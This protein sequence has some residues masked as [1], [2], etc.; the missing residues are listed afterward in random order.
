M[1][2]GK[3]KERTSRY[4]S[5]GTNLVMVFQELTFVHVKQT[6]KRI[7]H[8]QGSVLHAHTVVFSYKLMLFV[9]PLN[10]QNYTR[11]F[12]LVNETLVNKQTNTT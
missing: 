1:L 6:N 10:S 4:S 12:I 9:L 7:P 3:S 11:K 5:S 8:F 2:Q